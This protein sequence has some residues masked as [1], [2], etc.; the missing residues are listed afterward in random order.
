MLIKVLDNRIVEKEY[1]ENEGSQNENRITTLNLEVPEDYSDFIKKIVFITEDGNFFDYIQDDTYILKNNITKYRK[2]KAYI[3]LTN[4]TTHQDFRSQFFDLEF[5]YNENPS[6]YV[7]SEQQQTQWDLMVEQLEELIEEVE[8][9]PTLK[10]EIVEELPTEDID[11][12][13]IYMVPRSTTEP[14]NVYDEYM[15]INDAWEKIGS[16][17]VDLSNYYTKTQVD[18]SLADKVNKTSIVSSV[19]AS[20][21]NEQIPGAKLFYDTIGN[22]ESI[23]ETLDVG[24]GV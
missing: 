16:T 5:N 24:G 18:S 14:N 7:P 3:W 10:R 12:D 19:S 11:P 6:D 22:L 13:T 21:T 2:I 1:E 4:T 17:E 8:A 15:Y 9:L 20:S 23:L